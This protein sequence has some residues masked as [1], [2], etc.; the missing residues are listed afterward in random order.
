MY[1]I[2]E[3]LKYPNLFHAFSTRDEGNMA[4]VILGKVTDFD[5]VFKSRKNFLNRLGI[6]ADQSICMWVTHQDRVVIP[7]PK[8]RG[9]S[10][11]DFHYALK[12]DGMMTDKKNLY[13]FLLIADCLPIIIYD[14]VKSVLA[15]LHAGWKGLDLEIAKKG[16]KGLGENFNSN[17]K[18]LIIGIG[19]CVHKESFIKENPSQLNDPKWRPYL[20]KMKDDKYQVDLLGFVLEQLSDIHIQKKN[21]F[22]SKI[23]T[24]KD[25]RFFSHVRD[26]NLPISEQGRFA[27]IVG[28]RG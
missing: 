21:I 12:V 6:N 17:P 8:E 19:P 28:I 27:C 22:V 14:P 18:D 9:I 4:N 10:M 2:P 15:L 3:L 20:K 24:A 25:E 23:D 5:A 26:K 16:V 1:Q 7:D 11:R 13:L